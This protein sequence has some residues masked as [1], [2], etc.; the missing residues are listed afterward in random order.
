M[1]PI[2]L[3]KLRDVPLQVSETEIA[4]AMRPFTANADPKRWQKEYALRRKRLMK[5][6]RKRA[7]GAFIGKRR[8]DLRKVRSEYDTVWAAGYDRYI[9]GRDGARHGPWTWRNERILF[10]AAGASRFRCL[11]HAAVINAVKPRHVLEVGC[12]DGINLLQLSGAFPEVSFTGIDL[13]ASGHRAAKEAQERASLP[14][15][16]QSYTVLPIRDPLAFRRIEFVQGDA[17]A[18][19]F[20]D[21][22]FDLVM[23]VLSVE[24]MERV[25]RSAL[26]EIARV[27]GGYLLNLEPFREMNAGGLRRLNIWSRNYFAGSIVGMEEFGLEPQWAI[28]DLP[29]EALLGTALVLSRKSS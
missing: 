27:T 16:V 4:D 22:A 20:A 26:K 8:R 11:L 12:G 25:R 1:M 15:A 14:P 24:Q 9:S 28:A 17:T 3:S 13:T 6:L 18:M 29:Q 5:R 2:G 19:P 7:L 10:D 23:T 21:S